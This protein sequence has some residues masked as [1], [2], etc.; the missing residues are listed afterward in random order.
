MLKHKNIQYQWAANRDWCSKWVSEIDN[1]CELYKQNR[2]QTSY[3]HC[4]AWQHTTPQLTKTRIKRFHNSCTD[5][6]VHTHVHPTP[7]H[8]LPVRMSIQFAK[9]SITEINSCKPHNLIFPKL[10]SH[11]VAELHC[12]ALTVCVAMACKQELPASYED[13]ASRTLGQAAANT[14]VFVIRW[15]TRICKIMQDWKHQ[16]RK[17]SRTKIGT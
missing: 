1:V 16:H 6:H 17:T 8:Q 11:K 2:F 7:I 15:T 12:N 5:A 13:P 9:C 14:G 3:K 4:F 10:H